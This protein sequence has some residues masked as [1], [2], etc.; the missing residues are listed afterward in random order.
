MSQR[1]DLCKQIVASLSGPI[2]SPRATKEDIAVAARRDS[3]RLKRIIDMGVDSGFR[4]DLW[5]AL[6]EFGGS[7][8]GSI[9]KLRVFF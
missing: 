8:R 5:L 6:G 3:A 1:R 9:F 4:R 7:V 2:S